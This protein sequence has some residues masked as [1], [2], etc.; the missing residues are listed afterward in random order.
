MSGG[1]MKVFMKE[2]REGA[3]WSPV[4]G[5]ADLSARSGVILVDTTH[6]DDVEASRWAVSIGLFVA[7]G[8][9]VFGVRRE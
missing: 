3:K 5:P 6:V 1:K 7:R 4:P 2:S 8:G 9:E